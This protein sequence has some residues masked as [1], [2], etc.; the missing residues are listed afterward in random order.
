MFCDIGYVPEKRV[1]WTDRPEYI[2]QVEELMN[3]IEWSHLDGPSVVGNFLSRRVQ[4]CQ[5]RVYLG[6]E[7]QG[8]QD[9][10]RIHKDSLEK[11]EI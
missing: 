2:R 8:S 7:Y 11:L 10:T 3:L 1:S 5:R 9:T 4:P 6:F